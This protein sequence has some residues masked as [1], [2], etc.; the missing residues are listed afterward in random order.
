MTQSETIEIES[1]PIWLYG[2]GSLLFKPP[3]HHLPIHKH[4]HR[5]NGYTTGYIRR[6]WQSSYDNR[7]TPEYKGRVVTI[8][9]SEDIL[10]RKEF[11]DDVMTYEL[12]GRSRDI[13]ENIDK[14]NEELKVSGCIYYIPAEY[15]R[16]AAEYLDFREKDGYVTQE[17]E[18][19]VTDEISEETKH[20]LECHP[21]NDKNEAII[22]C[23]VYVGTTDNESFIGPENSQKTAHIIQTAEGESGK[24]DEYLLELEREI[25]EMGFNDLYLSELVELIKE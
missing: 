15:A 25:R 5:F 14:L 16:E 8:I 19:K 7:G 23:M 21:R 20:I 2:Y 22:K 24:N 3:L 13:F 4:F 12:K 9:P 17:I 1:Q 18:F 6:F 10:K 11:Q